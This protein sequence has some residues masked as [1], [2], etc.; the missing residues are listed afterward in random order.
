MTED[1]SARKAQ[2]AFAR[3][4]LVVWIVMLAIEVVMLVFWPPDGVAKKVAGL[5]TPIGGLAITAALLTRPRSAAYW[6]W[7]VTGFTAAIVAI[8]TVVLRL[9]AG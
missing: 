2:M 5:V 1:D 8:A 7:L 9:R 6:A 3:K 4:L